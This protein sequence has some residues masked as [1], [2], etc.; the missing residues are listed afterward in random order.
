MKKTSMSDFS[1]LQQFSGF[2]G[3]LTLSFLTATLGSIASVQ[4]RSFYAD[5]IQP[6][7]APP[8]WLF[9]PIWTLLYL[10]MAIAAWLVWR[11]DGFSSAR[12]ALIFFVVQL[13]V[14]ALWS[15]LF[16]AWHLGGAAF[17]DILVL[18]VLI[19]ATMLLFWRHSRIATL[20]LAPYFFWV[21]FA[22]ILN[23]SVWQL[24]PLLLS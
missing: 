20:L 16:F 18:I 13:A 21:C 24:N 4:A 11:R 15:W 2:L 22:A 8:G 5:L 10:M 14:N 9:G 7:W 1:R 17:A 6:A 12:F 19:A 3:W 23:F